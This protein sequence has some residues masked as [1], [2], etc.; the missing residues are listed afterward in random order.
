MITPDV[1]MYRR[2]R[3][4][5]I[6]SKEKMFRKDTD[7]STDE[8][9]NPDVSRGKVVDAKKPNPLTSEIQPSS[10]SGYRARSGRAVRKSK[11]FKD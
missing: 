5:I 8:E 2:N 6:T 4:D 11:Q 9:P 3:G 7:I 1:A 10:E